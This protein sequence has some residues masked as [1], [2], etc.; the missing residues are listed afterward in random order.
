M[1]AQDDDYLTSR[2][3][4]ETIT[5]PVEIVRTKHIITVEVCLN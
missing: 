4:A 2:L 1:L 3:I 5:I